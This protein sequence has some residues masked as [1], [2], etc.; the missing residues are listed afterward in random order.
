MLLFFFPHEAFLSTR[1]QQVTLPCGEFPE[2]ALSLSC[3][4]Y[5][6]KSID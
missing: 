6:C 4:I 3:L 2:W 1:L 5:F